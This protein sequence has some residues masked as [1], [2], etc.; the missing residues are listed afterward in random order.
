MGPR[1]TQI[2]IKSSEISAVTTSFTLT[3]LSVAT[4]PAGLQTGCLYFIKNIYTMKYLDVTNAST[5]SGTNVINWGYN[6][7]KG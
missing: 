6:G 5:Q 2:T 1:T 7:G 4:I 3:V